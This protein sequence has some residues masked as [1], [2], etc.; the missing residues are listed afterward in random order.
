[1]EYRTTIKSFGY[2]YPETKKAAHLVN[3]GM[4]INNL[5]KLSVEENIFL[6]ENEKRK[7]EFASIIAARLNAVD[8]KIVEFIDES[9][10][11]TSKLLVL[12]S[13]LKNDRL[14]FEFINEVYKEKIILNDLYIRDKDFASFFQTK[15][16]QSE[17]AAAWTEYTLKKIKQVYIRVLFDSGLIE[18]K[19]GDRKIKIPIIDNEIKEL[20][21]SLGDSAYINAILGINK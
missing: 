2:L 5:K 11:E 17:K 9:N 12:Y 6:L 20:I 14:L 3:K 21:Y 7:K 4:D 15:R 8:K 13:I 16:E 19:R 1:M 18:N 10:I